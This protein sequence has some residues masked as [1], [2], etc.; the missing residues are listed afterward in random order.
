MKKYLV[1]LLALLILF[2]CTPEIIDNSDDQ[3]CPD[4]AVDLGIVM[5]RE[6]GTTY[7][8]YWAKSNLGE[9]GLCANPEDV[10]DYYA[11]GETTT[12]TDYT[13][14]TYKWGDASSYS[15]IK[16]NTN[17]EYGTVDNK[18]VL[19]S[20]DDVAH[21]KLGGKWRIPTAREFDELISTKNNANYSWEW[22][23]FNGRNGW[24]VTYLVNNN[25]IFFP[26][27]GYRYKAHIYEEGSWGEYMSSS[28]NP[29][30]PGY[31]WVIYLDSDEFYRLSGYFYMGKSVRPVSE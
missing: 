17:K 16:Y 7:K 18:T 13:W 29:D 14:L 9:R 10:G 15:L 11:Y 19:D 31:A 30:I 23:S 26:A 22:K 20:K 4:G 27:A 2:A 28:I 24:L 6:D 25:S 3:N 8:L 12:K 5:T 21:F 1:G